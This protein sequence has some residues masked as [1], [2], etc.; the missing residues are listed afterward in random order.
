M[1]TTDICTNKKQ[2]KLKPSLEAFYITWSGNKSSLLYS[3]QR[4]PLT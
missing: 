4:G 1:K 2:I 3:S